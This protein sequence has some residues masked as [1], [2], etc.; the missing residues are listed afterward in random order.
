[1]GK[2]KY[3]YESPLCTEC[4]VNKCETSGI[5]KKDGRMLFKKKCFTCARI[6]GKEDTYVEGRQSGYRQAII[7][8]RKTMTCEACGFKAKHPC[9]LDIDHI[10]GNHDNN[11]PS[12]HQV[13][14]ANCHR[15]K[16]QENKDFLNKGNRES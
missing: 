9:Q 16:T 5:S 12:N 11:D 3:E 13:L 7:R 6:K 1:M 8:K 10:D 4:G 14:C 15:L 2:K